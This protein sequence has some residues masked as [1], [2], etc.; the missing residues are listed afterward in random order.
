LLATLL[1]AAFN[2]SEVE[3][4]QLLWG[5]LNDRIFISSDSLFKNNLAP[6]LFE[7]SHTEATN[8]VESG[9]VDTS[10]DSQTAMTSKSVSIQT[11]ATLSDFPNSE[12]DLQVLDSCLHFVV[13]PPSA[14]ISMTAT[15]SLHQSVK[16]TKNS[17]NLDSIAVRAAWVEASLMA[18]VMK[19]DRMSTAHGRLV[20]LIQV[21]KNAPF[22]NLCATLI[23][24]IN[25]G[26]F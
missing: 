22:V 11:P 8:S 23:L 10:A 13:Q 17:N 7:I 20:A 9:S 1:R 16:K 4:F 12:P 5:I 19:L 25:L 18:S 14:S 3:L 21:I 24:I 6:V 26:P 2:A 15:A